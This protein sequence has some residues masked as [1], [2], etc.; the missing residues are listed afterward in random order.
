MRN[1]I[2][3]LLL[4]ALMSCGSKGNPTD[5]SKDLYDVISKVHQDIILKE[6]I[7]Y[8]FPAPPPVKGM[9]LDSL[10]ESRKNKDTLKLIEELVKKRGKL[11]VAIDSVMSPPKLSAKTK[12]S[13]NECLNLGF[14]DQYQ[15]FKKLKDTINIDISR[16]PVSNYSIN[17][18]YQ[19]SYKSLP[20]KGFEKFDI[21]LK[22]STIAFNTDRTRACMV[23]SGSFGIRIGFTAIYF[24]RKENSK[25]IVDCQ[26][27]LS[28]S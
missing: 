3:C 26:K 27:M 4:L 17:I 12:S 9:N 15:S 25:W 21:Y 8:A 11:I 23:T 24:L 22:F 14:K 18:P 10:I 1:Y 2:I 20:L 19:K 28:I 16:L 5:N 13:V 7:S 6:M